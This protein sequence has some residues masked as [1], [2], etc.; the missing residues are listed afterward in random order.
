L[1]AFILCLFSFAYS[2]PKQAVSIDLSLYPKIDTED[3]DGISYSHDA[4]LGSFISGKVIFSKVK[5]STSEAEKICTGKKDAPKDC[6]IL[7]FS[8]KPVVKKIDGSVYRH[9]YYI[10]DYNDA[11]KGKVGE[12][13]LDDVIYKVE[14][15]EDFG[16]G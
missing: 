9:C 16:E 11:D 15:D 5:L 1:L 13:L 10:I 6:I 4:T 3:E 2:A 7:K 14:L 8:T 12:F